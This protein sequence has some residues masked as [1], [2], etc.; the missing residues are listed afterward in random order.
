MPYLSRFARHRVT[1]VQ[2]S[3]S[4]ICAPASASAAPAVP[5]VTPRRSSRLSSLLGSRSSGTDGS[6]TGGNVLMV[7]G[8]AECVLSRCSKVMLGDGSVVP[9]E[10]AAREELHK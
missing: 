9:L 4:V 5:G 10:K 1:P 7:K 2:K 8:A 3:M 6:S